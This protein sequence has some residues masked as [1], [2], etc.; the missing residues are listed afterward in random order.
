MNE[1]YRRIIDELGLFVDVSATASA[2]EEV[3]V[4]GGVEAGVSSLL[5]FRLDATLRS[6]SDQGATV[7]RS[8]LSVSVVK[9]QLRA[10]PVPIVIDDFH[11]IEEK[12]R[13]SVVRAVKD[14][15]RLTRV[16]MIAIPHAAFEPMRKVQDMDWRV[17]DL[18]VAR[19]SPTELLQI[20]V[21]GF[22]LLGIEDSGAEIGK[23]LAAESRG[24]PAIMQ[25]LC[26]E[27]VTEVLEIW[28]T[29]TP[30]VSATAPTDWG[31]FLESMAS[32]RKP[33]AFGALIQGKDTRG[34][35]RA[36]R[37]LHDGGVTDIYGAIFLTLSRMG[38]VD[39]VSKFDLAHKMTQLISD[40]PTAST[41]S[42]TLHNLADVAEKHRGHGDPALTYQDPE[43]QILDPFFAFYLAH[44]DWTLPLPA[45]TD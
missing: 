23:R 42:G 38:V 11:F 4:T 28:Q 12:V 39:H 21:D 27:Y 32:D 13:L 10:K 5:K 40:A 33:S 29:A 30:K 44:G 3:A 7:G 20:A 15:A 24:A 18:E 35:F 9:A 43:L 8:S 17:R 26:L 41:I 16:V 14:L 31:S 19:W 2:G 45:R 34:T 6:T 36:A 37:Q 22:R 1:L 25:A